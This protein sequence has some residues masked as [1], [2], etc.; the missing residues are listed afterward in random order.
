LQSI[1]GRAQLCHAKAT[2]GA[3]YRVDAGDFNACLAAAK[4]ASYAGPMTLIYA[5]D[6]DEWLGLEAERSCVLAM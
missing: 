6:G 5:D 2:V 4:A 3:G 1:F